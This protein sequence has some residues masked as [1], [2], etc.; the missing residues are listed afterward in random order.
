[1]LSKIIATLKN[2]VDYPTIV[3][4]VLTGIY[5]F[6]SDNNYYKRKGLIKETKIIKGIMYSY[7]TIALAMYVFLIFI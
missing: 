1:M 3:I 4:I 7:I 6:I 2:T 5:T